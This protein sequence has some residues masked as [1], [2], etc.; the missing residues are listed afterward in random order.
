[1]AVVIEGYSV[2]TEEVWFLITLIMTEKN[3]LLKSLAIGPG[4]LY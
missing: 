2:M 4:D 1:M 3:Y